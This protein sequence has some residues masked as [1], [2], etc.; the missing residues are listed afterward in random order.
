MRRMDHVQLLGL[1]TQRILQRRMDIAANNLANVNTTGFK[2]DALVLERHTESPARSEPKPHDIRFVRDISV[3]RDFR[4][5][6]IRLTGEAFDLAID[7]DGFFVVQGPNGPLY[8]RN[9]AFQLDAN[10]GLVTKDGY[11]VLNPEGQPVVLGAIEQAP[12]IGRDGA[13]MVGDA[14]VGRVNAVSFANN[15]LMEKF[16]DNLWSAGDMRP[17]PLQGRVTQ[18]ALENSN[19]NAVLELTRLIEISRAYESAARIVRSGDDLRKSVI[20]R[21]GRI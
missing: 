18:G 21:L 19:V 20:E 3:A 16:G 10:G 11:P 5:G 6:P 2:A 14:E 8:T 1:Q 12:K 9:G 13:I 7:G 4:A 15:R 17:G